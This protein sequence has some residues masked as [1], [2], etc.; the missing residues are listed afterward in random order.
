MAIFFTDKSRA[1]GVSYGA[2]Q[3]RDEIVDIAIVAM[4]TAMLDNVD[5]E[6]GL[7]WVP[8]GAVITGIAVSAT[9]MDTNGTPALAFDIGD[10]ADEDR[11]MVATQ[12]GRAGTVDQAIARTGLGY[13]YNT[14]TRL[15]AYVQTAAATAAAGTL[16]VVIRY[17]V[18]PEFSTTPLTA[19]TTA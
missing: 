13:K 18:D 6:V 19:T 8:A 10:D 7:M 5:D 12:V 17:F 9:D 11:L 16:T 2:G 4:T 3:A 14:R 1:F 15:K